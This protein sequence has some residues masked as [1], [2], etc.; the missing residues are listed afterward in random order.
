MNVLSAASSLSTSGHCDDEEVEAVVGTSSHGGLPGPFVPE[1]A[2]VAAGVF[3]VVDSVVVIV[4]E[5]FCKATKVSKMSAVRTDIS[6]SA[7]G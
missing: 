7:K 6:R 2:G 3:V 5:N 1:A 4:R